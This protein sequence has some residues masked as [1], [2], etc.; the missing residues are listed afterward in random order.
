[1]PKVRVI[2]VGAMFLDEAE[3]GPRGFRR[4]LVVGW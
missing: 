4:E 3:D 2:D 1:M